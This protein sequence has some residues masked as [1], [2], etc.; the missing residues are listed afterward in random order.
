MEVY[1]QFSNY[2]KTIEKKPDQWSYV[3]LGLSTDHE[4]IMEQMHVDFVMN[5]GRILN[6]KPKPVNVKH[7]TSKN[8]NMIRNIK[9]YSEY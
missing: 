3:K 4:R 7:T 8:N 5:T 6:T 2:D 9:Y 1:P